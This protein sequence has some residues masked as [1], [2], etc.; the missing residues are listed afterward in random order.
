MIRRP[1]RST[2]FPYTT[3]FRSAH[4]R[5]VLDNV[6]EGIVTVDEAHRISSFNP[7]AERLF[8]YSA[9]EVIG[10]DARLLLDSLSP[11]ETI[12]HRHGGQQ[13]PV[14]LSVGEMRRD[15]GGRQQRPPG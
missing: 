13:F 6:A 3:L 5:A 4:L 8:G 7:S 9:V 10:S 12:A 2:L 15:C 1:P 14:D 11:G